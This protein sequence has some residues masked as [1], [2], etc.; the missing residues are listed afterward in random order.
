[1]STTIFIKLKPVMETEKTLC[2]QL[3]ELNIA[4]N[5]PEYDSKKVKCEEGIR[6]CRETIRAMEVK[7]KKVLDN[8]KSTQAS[9]SPTKQRRPS[10][11]SSQTSHNS[12]QE[13]SKTGG[14]G[15]RD[16][17]P[18]TNISDIQVNVSASRGGGDRK[19]KAMRK[20]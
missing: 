9:R 5:D 15:K 2:Y 11:P 17:P 18:Q 6:K 16:D 3:A 10:R 1:M 4:N 13:E 19:S 20:E 7:L 12:M 14:G 8:V